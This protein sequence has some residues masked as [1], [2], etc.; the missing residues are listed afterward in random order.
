M[1]KILS[2][3]ILFELMSAALYSQE[4]LTQQAIDSIIA[5][6]GHT[7]IWEYGEPGLAIQTVREYKLKEALPA[8]ED[9]YWKQCDVVQWIS[10]DVLQGLKSAKFREIAHETIDS[11][12]VMSKRRRDNRL[13]AKRMR[14]Q[15]TQYLI[16]D[17]DFSTAQ[18]VFDPEARDIMQRRYVEMV[19]PVLKNVP[20]YRE[21]CKAAL[22]NVIHAD[23]DWVD[24]WYSLKALVDV[25]GTEVFPEIVWVFKNHINATARRFA[26]D[27][28]LVPL[29]YPGLDALLRERLITQ[30]EKGYNHV[31]LELL[32]KEFGTP[33]DY[34]FVATYC[35]QQAEPHFEGVLIRSFLFPEFIPP[36]PDSSTSI[37]TMIDSLISY[38]HQCYT[39]TW[40]GDQNYVKELDNH[41]TNAKKHLTKQDSLKCAREVE[42]FQAKIN[43]EYKEAGNKDKRFVTI[44][45]WKFLYYN[46]QYIIERLII[47]PPRSDASLL[48]QITALRTQIRTDAS[49]GLLGGE[50]LLKGLES[51]LDLAKQ[52]LQKKDSVGTALYVTLFQQTVRLTYEI[53]KKLPSSKLYVRAAGYISLYYRAGYI[54]EGLLEPVGQ[55]MPKMDS[56][57]E[58]ELQKYEKEV[59]EQMSR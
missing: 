58:K 7:K 8:I 41:L 16:K 59:N 33:S 48:D 18:Y 12:D 13:G 49:Q 25:L 15:A 50:L 26:L 28:F 34:N 10:L 30:A 23:S 3:F 2:I 52:R 46:A 17:G 6:I 4:K 56:A 43:K 24:T 44:E 5:S 47:L 11:A 55:P 14:L 40:L 57:L 27:D 51:S 29:K 22:I 35:D 39:Y 21:Q 9:N 42:M 37:E 54:L 20:A 32:I 36:K 38:K 19:S 1:K 31:F 53:T 45:G